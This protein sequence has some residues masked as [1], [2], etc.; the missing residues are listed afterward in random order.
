VGPLSYDIDGHSG[1]FDCSERI[2]RYVARYVDQVAKAR[3]PGD[4]SAT[5]K[6]VSLDGGFVAGLAVRR[7]AKAVTAYGAADASARAQPWYFDRDGAAEAQA[8]AAIN[9]DAQTQVPAHLDDAG[10]PRPFDFNGIANIKA[11]KWEPDG[12]TFGAAA[13]LLDKIPATFAVGAGE[14]LASTPGDVTV[15]WLCGQ[16]APAGPGKFRIALDRTYGSGATYLLARKDGTGAVRTSVQPC[17][18][19]ISALR[20]GEGQKQTITFD[21]PVEVKAGTDSIPLEAKSDA[22]LPVEY[23]VVAGPAVV[24]DGRLVFTPV[25]PRAKYPVTVTVAAWQW[26]RATEPKVRTA[27]VVRREL[28]LLPPATA[29]KP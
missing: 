14:A 1:H 11:V 23:F 27:D 26:G 20:N 12:V 3:L 19:Q 7:E 29:G 18:V 9:W 28:R 5:L 4:G 25:P 6:P 8:I 13:R 10:Q 16:V 21:L 22:G 17:G 2:T 24:K 15:E